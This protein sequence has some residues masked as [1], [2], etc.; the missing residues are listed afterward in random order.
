MKFTGERDAN[1]ESADDAIL[2][3]LAAALEHGHLAELAAPVA[4]ARVGEAWPESFQ[5]G[6]F[7]DWKTA[8]APPSRYTVKQVDDSP[9]TTM[10][11]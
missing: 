10:T 3:V 2:L 6:H 9:T 4:E 11:A 7:G 8:G 1:V 5:R